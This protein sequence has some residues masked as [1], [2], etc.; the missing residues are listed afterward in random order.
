MMEKVYGFRWTL[1]DQ[2]VK[3]AEAVKQVLGVGEVRVLEDTKE[4]LFVAPLPDKRRQVDVRE[5]LA[6]KGV[7]VSELSAPVP[8]PFTNPFFCTVKE[9]SPFVCEIIPDEEITEP[10]T[11]VRIIEVGDTGRGTEI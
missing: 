2:S 1:T 11:E 10:A 7:P 3:L 8:H 4:V 6:L 9:V 5:I